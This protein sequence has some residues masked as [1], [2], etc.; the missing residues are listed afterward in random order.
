ML[1][2]INQMLTKIFLWALRGFRKYLAGIREQFS[3]RD[4]WGSSSQALCSE[5]GYHQSQA[6]L[7][8]ASSCLVASPWAEIR[9]FSVPLFLCLTPAVVR[10]FLLTP[11]RDCPCCYYC[12]LPLNCSW[13]VPKIC[14]GLVKEIPL[15]NLS[16]C[17][18]G[19][20]LSVGALA[21]SPPLLPL[22]GVGFPD[23]VLDQVPHWC[24]EPALLGCT[25]RHHTTL[26]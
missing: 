21:G 1:K 9:S 7:L 25:P 11:S 2:N 17:G 26:H 12:L 15:R 8:G 23:P 16:V 5:G 3:Q 4:L 18:L 10:C 14:C 6:E 19:T 22:P 13:G 20:A 24:D